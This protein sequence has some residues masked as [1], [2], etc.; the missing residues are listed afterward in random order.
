MY[1]GPAEHI[2]D[3][4]M[5]WLGLRAGSWPAVMR[6]LELMPHAIGQEGVMQGL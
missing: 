5:N 1:W 4:E 2:A 3:A 6:S